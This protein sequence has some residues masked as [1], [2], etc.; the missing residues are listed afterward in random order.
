MRDEFSAAVKQKVAARAGY[1]CSN[2]AC[3]QPTSGPQEDP[4][5]AI[6]VGE[7][8]HITAAASGGPRYDPDLSPEERSSINNAIWLCRKCAKLI[9]ND[10]QRY[11]VALLLDW[12]KRREQEA[13]DA[14]EGRMP[15]EASAPPRSR[16]PQ[17][18]YSTGREPDLKELL[19][20]LQPRHFVTPSTD[21][22][23][24]TS[25]SLPSA[26]PFYLECGLIAQPS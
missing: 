1:R 16:P 22:Q 15:P 13:L 5:K 6:N 2:P 25:S 24:E 8:S 17:A 26:G 14:L 23:T 21:Y 10:P 9:D 20:R 4:A 7:A 12:G 3:R 18:P 11:T 19:A